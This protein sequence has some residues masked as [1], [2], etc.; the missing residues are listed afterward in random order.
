LET[1]VPGFVSKASTPFERLK[2]VVDEKETVL[3]DMNDF[4]KNPE[5]QWDAN[6]RLV[7][8]DEIHSDNLGLYHH[9]LS[10]ELDLS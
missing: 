5:M 10:L 6:L 7:S 8:E 4:S 2:G 1:F 3:Q 9:L